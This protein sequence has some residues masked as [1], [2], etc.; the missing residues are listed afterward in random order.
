MRFLFATLLACMILGVSVASAATAYDDVPRDHW[1]YN[2]LDYLTDRGV[3]EGYPDGFFKGDRTLTRYEFAQAIARLLDSMGTGGGTEV[4]VMAETLRAEFSDQLAELNR[5]LI[6]A[7]APPWINRI[8]IL[9]GA[10]A[11]LG[12]TLVLRELAK[13]PPSMGSP[14]E[15]DSPALSFQY[16]GSKDRGL[17]HQ[18]CDT[19]TFNLVVHCVWIII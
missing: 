13:G 2:A 8:L 9:S 3:L 7:E 14:N 11:N 4:T 16:S 12:M 15:G 5:G 6:E 18:G 19:P 17:G 10:S 1:A